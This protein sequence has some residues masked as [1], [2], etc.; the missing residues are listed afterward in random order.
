M[1]RALALVLFVAWLAAP[2]VSHAAAPATTVERAVADLAGADADRRDA[3]V[4]VL[5]ATGDGKWLT[6]LAALRDGNV[7]AR[8]TGGTLELVVAGAK[9]TRGDKDVVELASAIA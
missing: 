9:S 7:Y 3:A 1:I 6:F 4:A 5:G 2:A 8:K